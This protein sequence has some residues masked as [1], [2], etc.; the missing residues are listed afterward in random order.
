MTLNIQYPVPDSV[1]QECKTEIIWALK[2][3]RL[4]DP[5]WYGYPEME[6]VLG[7]PIQDATFEDFQR[8]FKCLNLQ[9]TKCNMKGLDF[10]TTCS[11]LPCDMCEKGKL[12]K[13]LREVKE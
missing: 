6:M 2:T 5:T 1:P 4:K 10:P 8:I 13:G 12:I 9:K 7:V 11:K 3:G